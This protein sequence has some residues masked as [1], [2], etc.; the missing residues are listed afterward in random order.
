MLV[1]E[2]FFLGWVWGAKDFKVDLHHIDS[3]K[4]KKLSTL[5]ANKMVDLNSE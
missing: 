1:C 5:M 4:T 2:Y 3:Q